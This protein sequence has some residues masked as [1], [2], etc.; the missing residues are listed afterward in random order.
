MLRQNL[1]ILL[2]AIFFSS[3]CSKQINSALPDQSEQISGSSAIFT[4]GVASGDPRETSVVLW[5]SIGSNLGDNPKVEWTMSSTPD[6]NNIVASGQMKRTSDDATTFKIKA[7]GLRPSSRYF[8]QF[9]YEGQRSVVGKTKTI[10]Q[11]ETLHIGVVSCANYEAGYFNSYDALAKKDLD[12]VMHLGDYIYEYGPG[13]YGDSTIQRKHVPAREIVSLDDYRQ[14]YAQYR[15]DESLQLVH[16]NHPFVNIWDDHEISNNAYKDGAENHQDDEGSYATRA[17]IAK[18][19]YTEWMPTELGMDEPLYRTYSF[20]NMATVVMLDGRLEGRTKQVE[21][22]ASTQGQSMLG[23]TQ[24]EWMKNQLSQSTANWKI[25]GNQVIFSPMNLSRVSQRTHNMDAWDGYAE[26]RNDIVNFIAIQQLQDVLIVSG[27]THMSWGIEV[28]FHA[29]SYPYTN[30]AVAVEIG[31]PSISSSN[32]NESAPTEDVI[33]AERVLKASNPHLKFV[34]GRNHGYVILN[35]DKDTA[36]IDWY[37]V[38]NLKT[39]KY[40]ERRI[41]TMTVK[42]GEQNKLK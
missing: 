17:A 18:Q 26:E 25:L 1:L 8:Y 16:Q 12:L 33:F 24:L 2:I 7:T 32:L 11:S 35:L 13:T 4:H 5:T 9:T 29:E 21:N 37:A 20:G 38:S 40:T 19:A 28:P 6:M 23:N 30:E 36:I 14:R 27:D 22:G 34:D 31:I 10:G 39:K 3:S 41:K 15:M 42:R